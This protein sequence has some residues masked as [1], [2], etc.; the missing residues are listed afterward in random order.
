MSV[1]FFTTRCYC[2]NAVNKTEDALMIKV[3]YEFK[4]P[5]DLADFVMSATPRLVG[6]KVEPD[7]KYPVAP[8]KVEPAAKYARPPSSSFRVRAMKDLP[9]AP[10][11]DPQVTEPVAEGLSPPVRQK[12][13]KSKN[14]PN[15]EDR[16]TSLDDVRKALTAL[17]ES[18]GLAACT[19][20]LAKFGISR[21]TDLTPV[22]YDAF[23]AECRVPE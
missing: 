5:Q 10:D 20:L 8:D 4:T 17:A 2:L 11:L 9:V 12:A 1:A 7:V 14:K 16:V 18:K 21:L 23:I 3:T 13:R 15:V 6:A 19:D 22:G